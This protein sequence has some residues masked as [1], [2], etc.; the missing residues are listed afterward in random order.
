MLFLL[1]SCF[2]LLAVLA[3]PAPVVQISV[4]PSILTTSNAT[5]AVKWTGVVNASQID[6]IS[7][8]TPS[9]SSIVEEI[10]WMITSDVDEEYMSGSGFF[11]MPLI[12][13]F[14]SLFIHFLF[15]FIQF[16]HFSHFLFTFYSLFIHFLFTFYSLFIHF[17]FTFYSLFIHFLFTFYF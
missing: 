4:S 14:Y 13:I 3:L 16:S 6:F 7:I 2:S 11:M 17:L 8:Y 12:S 9:S 5:I 1:S 10:G 15:T